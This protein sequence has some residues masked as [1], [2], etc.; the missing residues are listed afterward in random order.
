MTTRNDSNGTVSDIV[1]VTV[2]GTGV[3]AS[4]IATRNNSYG[5]PG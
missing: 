2:L 3:L 5:G 1:R 4:Q